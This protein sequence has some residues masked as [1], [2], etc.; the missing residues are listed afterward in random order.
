MKAGRFAVPGALLGAAL[1]L[2]ACGGQGGLD[3]AKQACAHVRKSITLYDASLHTNDPAAVR[4]DQNRASQQLE[5]AE[6]LAAE[7]NSS[8]SGQW[9]ALMTTLEEV[10]QVDEGNLITALRA[11]CSVANSAQAGLPNT[12]VTLPPVPGGANGTSSTTTTTS[13][14][15]GG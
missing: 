7:A 12:P 15:S 1:G 9:G 4:R 5:I 14:P 11:Q 2:A 3:L 8:A 10:G 13:T 6:P